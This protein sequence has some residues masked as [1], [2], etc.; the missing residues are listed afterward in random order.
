[1]KNLS[2]IFHYLTPDSSERKR[3]LE[4]IV[5]PR[6]GWRNHRFKMFVR[7][8]VG[9]R[10]GHHMVSC[11]DVIPSP[12]TCPCMICKRCEMSMGGSPPLP[13]PLDLLLPCL[14]KHHPAAVSFRLTQGWAPARPD[15]CKIMTPAFS[16]GSVNVIPPYSPGSR[17][18]PVFF[19]FFIYCF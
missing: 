4:K 11:E 2:G 13:S 15:N 18:S 3:L 10:W 9:G 19:D 6:E 7:S 17:L 8:A 14:L 16:L 5:I 12:C 1:M